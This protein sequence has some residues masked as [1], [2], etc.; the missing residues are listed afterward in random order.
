MKQQELN[1]LMR[2][3]P[4]AIGTVDCRYPSPVFSIPSSPKNHAPSLKN[5]DEKEDQDPRHTQTRSNQTSMLGFTVLRA[6][7]YPIKQNYSYP[8]VAVATPIGTSQLQLQVV[9]LVEITGISTVKL[10][11][12]RHDTTGYWI[13]LVRNWEK[14]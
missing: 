14:S 4:S 8:Q 12:V 9:T 11:T 5:P 13:L 7:L 3:S 6:N 1:S 10:A 2:T